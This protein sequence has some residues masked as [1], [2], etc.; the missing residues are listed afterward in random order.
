[1]PLKN[2]LIIT[3]SRGRGIGQYLKRETPENYKYKT[4]FLPG[5]SLERVAVEVFQQ[6]DRQQYD[7]CIVLAGI[8][9]LTEKFII[10][11]QRRL[12]Y[13]TESAADKVN[14]ILSTIHDLNTRLTHI[15]IATIIPASLIKHFRYHNPGCEL[16]IGLQDEDKRL[17]EDIELI[18]REIKETNQA[19]ERRTINLYARVCKNS[20]RKF[21]GQARTRRKSRFTDKD[22]THDIHC[23]AALQKTCFELVKETI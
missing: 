7:N 2:I 19:H 9:G 15:N 11:G 20:L 3:D 5:A 14:N 22:L 16:P 6:Y 17:L 1:M 13:P 12:H 8:C 10:R 4:V 18:N 21:R 23:N